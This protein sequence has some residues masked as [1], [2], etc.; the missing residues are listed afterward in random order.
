MMRTW[1]FVV[2]ILFFGGVWMGDGG[3]EDSQMKPD[4]PRG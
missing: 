2:R 1:T 4:V 3:R